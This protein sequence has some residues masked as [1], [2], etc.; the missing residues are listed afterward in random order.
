MD[1]FNNIN[2]YRPDNIYPPPQVKVTFKH[3]RNIGKY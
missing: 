3:L 1:N 2:E